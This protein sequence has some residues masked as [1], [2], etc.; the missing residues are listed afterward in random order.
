[1]EN[2]PLL[3]V[4]R[5]L[6]EMMSD[7]ILPN[8]TIER[9]SAEKSLILGPA[10]ERFKEL[11]RKEDKNLAKKEILEF[12]QVTTRILSNHFRRFSQIYGDRTEWQRRLLADAIVAR[13][14]HEEGIPL[15]EAP[16][17]REQLA[18]KGLVQ[19]ILI[20]LFVPDRLAPEWVSAIQLVL[21]PN[22]LYEALCLGAW[23]RARFGAAAAI[24]GAAVAKESSAASARNLSVP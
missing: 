13:S 3:E 17:L 7:K 1:M 11:S 6:R 24:R 22:T 10:L 2:D 23:I 14:L 15:F 8:P 20:S 12:R 4:K 19:N 5:E 16:A 21:I 18:R 9:A